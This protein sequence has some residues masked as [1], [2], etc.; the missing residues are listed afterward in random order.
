[1]RSALLRRL[2]LAALLAPPLCLG[3]GLAGFGCASGTKPLIIKGP[4]VK[5]V[6]DVRWRTMRAE[7]RVHIDAA[8]GDGREQTDVRG[9]IA[10]E[11]PD[12]FRLRAVGPGGITLF[13]IVKIG[14][15]I[16]IVQGVAGADS[17]LQEKV[18]LAIGADL[19][20]AYD[21]EPRLPSRN[22]TVSEREEELRITEPERTVRLQQFKEVQ[23]QSVPT[24]ME[25]RNSAL[26]YNVTVDVESATLDE[27]LDPALFRGK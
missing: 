3:G 16:K 5:A 25:I 11:R 23:G 7:H 4:D 17:S 8:K 22:K 18:L 15:D 20:A 13:D 27:K 19:A 6:A 14:G 21:L 10:I 12:R 1:M 24:R 26:D 9:M 2:L